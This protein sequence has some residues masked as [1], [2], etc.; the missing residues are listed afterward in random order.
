[1]P[2]NLAP[3]TIRLSLRLAFCWAL[4][5]FATAVSAA[6][7]GSGTPAPKPRF[8]IWEYQI[9]GNTT[10]D[11][12]RIE[13]AVYPFLGEDK[14]IDDVEQARSA[15]EKSYRDGGYATASVSIP[16]QSVSGGVVEL[17]VTEG[18]VERLRISGARYY[19]QGRIVEQVAAVAEGEVPDFHALEQQLAA[20][21]GG[22]DRRVQPLLRPGHEPGTTEIE[23]K[24][25]DSRPLH[26]SIELN[27][28]YSPSRAPH[29]GDYRASGTLRYDNLWQRE[30]SFSLSYL[31]SPGH[32]T[33]AKVSS[34]AYTL[35]LR[36][37]GESLTIYGVHSNSNSDLTTSLAGT[38]VLGRGDVVGLRLAEP[39]RSVGGI[40]HS[41]TLGADYKHNLED[42]VQ[43]GSGSLPTPLTYWLGSLQYAGARP[44]ED[45][46][47]AFGAGL[48][49]SLRSVRNNDEQF[50]LK[51]YQ[52]QG[53]FAALR[54]NAQRLQH[55][56]AKFDL[57]ARLE[58]Q[59]ASLPLPSTEQYAAGGADS[60]R[61]YPEG[62]QVGDHG[63]R[64]LLELRTP[65]LLGVSEGSEPWADLRLLGFV[66]AAHLRILSPL[67]GQT[68]R[69]TLASYG[70]GLRF[71][72]VSGV[73][74]SLDCARR[75]KDGLTT[76]THGPVDKGGT[77]L[78]F[79]LGY[80]L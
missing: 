40:S 61:G 55:L 72:T 35:P 66:D 29:P 19:A 34:A 78:H 15:L 47:T 57:T 52:G 70:I 62:V 38:S 12:D 80:Q 51:R 73:A 41:L 14:S 37:P 74:L 18:R 58:G 76:D 17:S 16:E 77:R 42:L 36:V 75:L 54:W 67:P 7:A 65:S 50:A 44:D 39:I 27:N 6:D 22:A 20:V 4:L 2:V 46:E 53:N 24:V 63:V 13:K 3:P 45:G 1:M 21:N 11:T 69:F 64:G 25:D 10:L 28:R 49:L 33:E 56:P 59:L 8:D 9:A 5:Q 48:S 26:G 31:T 30:H 32:S 79:S 43:D 23:L 68:S 71:A 60:V